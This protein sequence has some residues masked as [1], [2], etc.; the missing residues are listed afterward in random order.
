[1][2]IDEGVLEDVLPDGEPPEEWVAEWYEFGEEHLERG[3]WRWYSFLWSTAINQFVFE[4]LPIAK[5]GILTSGIIQVDPARLENLDLRFTPMGFCFGAQL[6]MAEQASENI[7]APFMAFEMGKHNVVL[8]LMNGSPQL[9]GR[10]PDPA[11]GTGAC[12]VKATGSGQFWK[13]GILSCR[14]TTDHLPLMSPVN[15]HLH[16]NWRQPS[17]GYLAERQHPRIEAAVIGFSPSRW[18]V[19]VSRLQASGLQVSGDP[20]EMEGRKSPHQSGRIAQVSRRVAPQY[21]GNMVPL[22]TQMDI[23]GVQGDSGSLV[24]NPNSQAASGI[25]Y[26]RIPDGQGGWLGLAQDMAQVV[27]TINCELYR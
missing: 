22:W 24:V 3:T 23:Y 5:Y 16:S 19:G 8:S 15:M 13:T 27:S 10:P 4:R 7:S 26:G 9:D 1:M 14:H 21:T 25:Y 18:P 2:R 12:W 11:G 6:I 20:V 17:R